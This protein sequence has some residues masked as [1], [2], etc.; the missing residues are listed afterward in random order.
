MKRLWI[1]LS[2]LLFLFAL[3][4]AGKAAVTVRVDAMLEH[5]ART[6]TAAAQG[7]FGDASNAAKEAE[8]YWLQNGVLLGSLLRHDEADGVTAQL[9]E[10]RAY[11]ET[12]DRDE[13]LAV[14]AAAMRQLEHIREMESPLVQNVL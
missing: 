6:Q 5:L 11:A 13:L 10:L 7:D 14:C 3:C 12:G 2:T 1:A 8:D 9:A 4:A